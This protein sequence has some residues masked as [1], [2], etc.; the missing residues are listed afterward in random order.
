MT[1]D[2]RLVEL[3]DDQNFLTA[4]GSPRASIPSSNGGGL[5]FGAAAA[6]QD[7]IAALMAQMKGADQAGRTGRV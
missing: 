2:A 3:N 7:R 6:S 5:A 1:E 4:R